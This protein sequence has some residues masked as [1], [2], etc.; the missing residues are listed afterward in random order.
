MPSFNA[1]I[2]LY[3]KFY[4][5]KDKTDNKFNKDLGCEI[6]AR[7]KKCNWL[8]LRINELEEESDK[9]YQMYVKMMHGGPKPDKS[10]IERDN[11]IS[12][13]MELMTECF[14]FMAFRLLKAL[15]SITEFKNLKSDGITIIRNKLLEHPEDKDSQIWIN[16]FAHHGPKGPVL[17]AVRYNYQ[18]DIFP[19]KGLYFNASELIDNISKIIN[20]KY[21][22][23]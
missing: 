13:E 10:I 17:K 16:S 22:G 19:D 8:L 14:Y 18:K 9:Y 4:R 5:W 1:L 23:A 2:E 12:D 11:E 21:K 3:D 20:L 7:M 6:R 15:K